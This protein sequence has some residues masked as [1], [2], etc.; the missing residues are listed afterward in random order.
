[1]PEVISNNFLINPLKDIKKL[2]P[3]SKSSVAVLNQ[4]THQKTD[5]NSKMY[6]D[7][8]RIQLDIFFSPKIGVIVVPAGLNTELSFGVNYKNRFTLQANAGFDFFSVSSGLE[9]KQVNAQNPY[10]SYV[11]NVSGYNFGSEL[12]YETEKFLFS[13]GHNVNFYNVT[14]HEKNFTTTSYPVNVDGVDAILSVGKETESSQ[15]TQKV[16]H[17]INMGIGMKIFPQLSIGI[18]GYI[19]LTPGDSKQIE[20]WS[21]YRFNIKKA[22]SEKSF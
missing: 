11:G 10:L 16:N 21:R 13:L 15:R 14:T 2:I 7:Q 20:F 17:Q 22:E 1:M 3:N 8:K 5:T 4:Q 18:K 6:D 9:K 19:N 12:G